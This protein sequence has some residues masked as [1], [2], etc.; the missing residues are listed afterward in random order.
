MFKVCTIFASVASAQYASYRTNWNSS[1]SQKVYLPP[2]TTG[3]YR[4]YQPSYPRNPVYVQINEQ[5]PAYYNPYNWFSQ[6]KSRSSVYQPSCS[7]ISVED[8]LRGSVGTMGINQNQGKCW[9]I[10]DA[11]RG[12]TLRVKLILR[13]DN[14]QSL[15][16]N[17]KNLCQQNVLD[18]YDC[19]EQNGKFKIDWTPLSSSDFHLQWLLIDADV[20]SEAVRCEQSRGYWNPYC[21]RCSRYPPTHISHNAV[22]INLTGEKEQNAGYEGSHISY[23]GIRG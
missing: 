16:I 20:Q 21:D 9:E 22:C 23:Y 5:K 10:V 12:S 6:W 13:P 14:C 4:T 19:P 17:N 8:T 11:P 2:K 3:N 7:I 1:P 15:T 18:Q